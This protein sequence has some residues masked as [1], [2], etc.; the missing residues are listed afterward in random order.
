MKKENGHLPFFGIGPVLC[1]PMA[2]VT[3][4]AILL[5]VKGILPLTISDPVCKTVMNTLGIL[6][7][8]EGLLCFFGADFKGG[9]MKSI[10]NNQLKTNGSYAFV[11]NPCYCVY[12]LGCTGALLLAH[13]PLLLVLPPL[14]WLEMT[15]VL[16]NTEEKWLTELYGQ[17]YLDY[18][19][20]VNRCIPWFPQKK[21]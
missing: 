16:K 15:I 19:R 9:L 13:N 6:L 4:I 3:A 10:R 20:Q 21:S 5:S 1:F 8:L 17:Q 12:L 18:C 7:I 2:I 11:R 14:F